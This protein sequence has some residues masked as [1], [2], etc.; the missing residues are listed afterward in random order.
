MTP[1]AKSGVEGGQPSEAKARGDERRRAR[2]ELRRRR[3]HE[4]VTGVAKAVG[5]GALITVKLLAMLAL[6]GVA[7]L[8]GYHGYQR[9]Q[10][11]TYF[12]V[13][14]VTISGTRHSLPSELQERIA[15]VKGRSIF[16]L[17]LDAVAQALQ[18]HPWVKRAKVLRQLPRTLRVE[19]VEHRVQAAILLGHFY[20]VSR[21]G[22]VFKRAELAEAEGLPLITGVER[23]ELVTRPKR[24]GERIKVA[25]GA[26]SAYQRR[27]RPPLSEV[28]IGAGDEVTFFLRKSGTALRFGTR[29]SERRLAQLD[30]IWAALGADSGR[31]RALYF[32]HE[33]RGDQ[34]VVRMAGGPGI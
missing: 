23:K 32:D 19:I 4:R 29:L 13:D 31:A 18:R 1:T 17:E 6:L 7:G 30:A 21:E 11:S 25:L 2:A 28:H 33:V 26:L 22:Q 3:L 14:K 9:M 20:L 8:G 5:R 12:D 16:D 10:R 24:A 27:V 34:V 15:G